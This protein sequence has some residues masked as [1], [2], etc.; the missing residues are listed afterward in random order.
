[1]ARST[2]QTIG[3]I[4]P[5]LIWTI[6]RGDTASFRVFVTDDA[7]QPINVEDWTIKADVKRG[8]TLVVSLLPEQLDSDGPGEFTVSLTSSE[9][10]ELETD[11]VFDIQLS[12]VGYVW[13]V[14]Q[15]KMNVIE[16]VTD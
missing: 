16:D 11:D 15:G 14:A 3:S 6:V 1:M 4:P 10:E 5:Q 9:S 12:T 2:T 7:K 8:S 13:T